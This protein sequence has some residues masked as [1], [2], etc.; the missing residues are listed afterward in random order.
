MYSAR[1]DNVVILSSLYADT[2]GRQITTVGR[3]CCGDSRLVKRL[4]CHG[5]LSRRVYLRITQWFSNNWP[6]NLPWPDDIPRPAPSPDS[7]AAQPAATASN[8][9]S[10][11]ELNA[12]GTIADPKAF[13]KFLGTPP[14]SPDTLRD[15]LRYYADGKPK[16][17]DRPWCY[18]DRERVLD[19]LVAAGDKRFARRAERQRKYAVLSAIS[20][21]AS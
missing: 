15:V 4:K 6:H 20:G 5:S 16:E 2:T 19:A 1:E 14:V 11:L 9:P 7:P 13:L 17:N 18:S 10:G 3:L 8:V 12:M 21:L